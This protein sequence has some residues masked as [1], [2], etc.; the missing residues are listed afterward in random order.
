M[1]MQVHDEL[2]LEVAN[3]A[4]EQVR[5]EVKRIMEQVTT[6]AVPLLVEIGTGPD[7]D[8]AAQR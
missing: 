6:L 7:W 8:V 3:E 5:P 1:I 2:V 4:L